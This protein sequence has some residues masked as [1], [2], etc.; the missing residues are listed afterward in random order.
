MVIPSFLVSLLL[1]YPNA[2]VVSC[3]AVDLPIAVVS[4]VS[5]V[6]RV[7][8]L[9]SLMLWASMPLPASLLVLTFLLLLYFKNNPSSI[10][11]QTL[12]TTGL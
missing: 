1:A 8:G 3:V 2:P 9:V 6:A 4:R 12:Q 10:K 5:V 7:S 11:N